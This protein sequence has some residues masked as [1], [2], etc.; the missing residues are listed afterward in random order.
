MSGLYSPK[1]KKVLVTGSARGIGRDI[2]MRLAREGA[3]I[4]INYRKRD[5]EAERTLNALRKEGIRAYAIKAD[6]STEEGCKSVIDGAVKE[7]GGIDILVNNA[8][9]GFYSPFRE[10]DNKLI[11]KTID[12]DFKSTIY[13]CLFASR[14]M[15]EG[16][17]VNISSITGILPYYGLSI[18]SS[19]K[20]GIIALTKSLAIELHPKIRVNAVAPG[21]VKTDLGESL[22]KVMGLDWDGWVNSYTLASAPTNTDEIAEAVVS[23][24]RISTM[25]GQVIV[26]DGGQTLVSGRIVPTKK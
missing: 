20:G 9:V 11:D 19:V 17:I 18:Y 4:V 1:G 2:A 15:K 24:I 25:T 23:C 21:L 3:D 8:G 7:M 22:L 13:C 5:D 12:T 26:V 6:L 14:V 16:V 10:I